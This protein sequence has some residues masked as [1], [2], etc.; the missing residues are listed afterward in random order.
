MRRAPATELFCLGRG[1][2]EVDEP[3]ANMIS[4]LPLLF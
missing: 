2:A 1:V 4:T 3:A